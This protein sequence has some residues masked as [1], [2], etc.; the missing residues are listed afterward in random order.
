MILNINM[1]EGCMI[2]K[3]LRHQLRIAEVLIRNDPDNS[4][5][6]T[7]LALWQTVLE[8]VEGK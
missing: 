4:M 1:E 5:L 7:E 6:H 8:K 2:A 3:A